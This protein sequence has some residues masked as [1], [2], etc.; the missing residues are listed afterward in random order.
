M[1]YG[2]IGAALA[3]LLILLI[4]V[5]PITENW[6][7]SPEDGF[8]LSYYPMFAKQRDATE[9]VYHVVGMD[10]AGKRYNIPYNMVGTGGFNQIRRQIRKACRSGDGERL[11][12][13]VSRKVAAASNSPYDELVDL[14]LIR[15][16]YA[17]EAYLMEGKRL[18]TKEK[19]YAT[20][21]ISRYDPVK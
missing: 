18:P 4:V 2:K 9:P 15:G 5:S 16:T 11:I 3:S 17:T 12:E 20:D 19:I 21:K 1:K 10:A 6:T 7:S 8:P 13:R 14:R